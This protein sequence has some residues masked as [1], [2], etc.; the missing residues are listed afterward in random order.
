MTTTAVLQRR[1]DNLT[2]RRAQTGADYARAD[3]PSR[4]LSIPATDTLNISLN[5]QPEL[6][7]P[8]RRG[9]NRLQ[10]YGAPALTPSASANSP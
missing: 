6:S 5:Y 9:T 4:H 3:A 1:T 8:A 7:P 2:Q 10:G